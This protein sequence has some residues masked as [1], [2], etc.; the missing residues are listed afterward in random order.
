MA[1]RDFFLFPKMKKTLKGR[2]FTN[3]DDIKNASLNERKA[4]PKIEF[5]KCFKDWQKRWSKCIVSNGDDFEGDNTKILGIFLT[6]R[7]PYF[8]RSSELE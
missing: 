5:E 8:L 1:P 4:I 6:H 2:R 3:I 7:V